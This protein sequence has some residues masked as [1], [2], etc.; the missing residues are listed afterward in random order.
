MPLVRFSVVACLLY[1]ATLTALV[2][3]TGCLFDKYDSDQ[4]PPVQPEMTTTGTPASWNVEVGPGH[5]TW[6]PVAENEAVEKIAGPQG[7]HHVWTSLLVSGGLGAL[8][9]MTVEVEVTTPPGVVISRSQ[10]VTDGAKGP[11]GIRIEGLYA[12][13]DRDTSG[14]IVVRATVV[15]TAGSGPSRWARGE[16][17][18][19]VR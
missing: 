7:G 6:V 11:D 1:T 3:P 5:D 14:P 10:S 18:V 17:R 12:Y 16:K 19:L 4:S 2:V 8:H 13:V 9:L 15:D